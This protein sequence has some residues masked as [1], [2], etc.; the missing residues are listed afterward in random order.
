MAMSPN[1]GF[2][3]FAFYLFI[4]IIIWKISVCILQRRRNKLQ[5]MNKILG[6]FWHTYTVNTG[7]HL[8]L[9]IF[10]YI[11]CW[12]HELKINQEYGVIY[13]SRL[14]QQCGIELKRPNPIVD[15]IQIGHLHLKCS[16]NG[17]HCGNFCICDSRLKIAC[18]K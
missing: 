16:L 18:N 12:M 15:H 17:S 6:K 4:I 13:W 2:S 1:P 3:W 5:R 10:P 8:F 14:Y 9:L 7:L 11:F